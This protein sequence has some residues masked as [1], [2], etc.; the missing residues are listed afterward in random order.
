MYIEMPHFDD[1]CEKIARIL[2]CSFCKNVCLVENNVFFFSVY[3]W[4]QVGAN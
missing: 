2:F 3:K 1:E 4:T